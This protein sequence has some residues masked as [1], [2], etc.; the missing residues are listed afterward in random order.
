MYIKKKKK[1]LT[2]SGQRKWKMNMKKE[3]LLDLKIFQCP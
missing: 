1:R 3:N 2:G